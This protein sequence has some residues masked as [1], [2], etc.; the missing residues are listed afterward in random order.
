MLH[1]GPPQNGTFRELIANG[2]DADHV[3]DL[4]APP[5]IDEAAA[6]Q[7]LGPIGEVVDDADQSIASFLS[8]LSE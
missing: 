3:T 1:V 7:H 6:R 5:T 8:R 4:L 2:T